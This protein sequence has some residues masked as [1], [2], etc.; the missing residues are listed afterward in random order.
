MFAQDFLTSSPL[1]ARHYSY[2]YLG[3]VYNGDA[4]IGY[5]E[6]LLEHMSPWPQSC[7]VLVIDNCAI[8]HL[9]DIAPLCEA[10]KG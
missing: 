10:V 8:H 3:S 9:D 2:Q 7:S 4:F 1:H 5:V 6:E